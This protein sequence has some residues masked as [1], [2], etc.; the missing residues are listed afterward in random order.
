M[1]FFPCYVI[2]HHVPFPFL[3]LSSPSLKQSHSQAP[4]KKEGSKDF[5]ASL[6][7]NSMNFSDVI[8]A[9][10]SP[11]I[12]AASRVVTAR[13]R[14]RVAAHR[15]WDTE[16]SFDKLICIDKAPISGK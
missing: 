6:L 3:F 12:T 13:V 15:W 1:S 7:S 11:Q 4:E 14:P 5:T 10:L 16:S 2:S 8:P 9:V